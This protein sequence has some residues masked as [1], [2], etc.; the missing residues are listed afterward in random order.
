MKKQDKILQKEK[1][2]MCE[3]TGKIKDFYTR[4][5][6]KC[7]RCQGLGEVIYDTKKRRYVI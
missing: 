6:W 4:E 1:C 5:L 3:G 2:W 7:W